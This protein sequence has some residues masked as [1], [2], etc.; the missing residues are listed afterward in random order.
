MSSVSSADVNGNVP[1][2]ITLIVIHFKD[3]GSS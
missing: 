2:Y 3:K 1:F